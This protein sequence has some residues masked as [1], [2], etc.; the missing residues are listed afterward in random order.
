MGWMTE[1]LGFESLSGQEIC[2]LTAP[3]PA[4]GTTEVPVRLILMA[5]FSEM[6]WSQG[7]KLATHLDLVPRLIMRGVI[8]LFLRTSFFMSR[9]LVKHR[10]NFAV[11]Y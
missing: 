7:V 1:E 4:L 2:L 6:K 3:R 11:L 9:C 8:P 5:L 10:G